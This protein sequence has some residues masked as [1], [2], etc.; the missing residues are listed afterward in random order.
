MT[1][2][3]RSILLKKTDF[4]RRRICIYLPQIATT[5][6]FRSLNHPTLTVPSEK[7]ELLPVRHAEIRSRALSM[8][9]FRAV[10]PSTVDVASCAED[11]AKPKP[12]QGPSLI[13]SRGR[14]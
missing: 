2:P 11:A 5:V 8:A 9:L 7:T 12:S 10:H 3:I 14:A 4:L 13:S 6:Q 1:S